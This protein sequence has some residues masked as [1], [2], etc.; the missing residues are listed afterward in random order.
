M[1]G[2]ANGVTMQVSGVD[3]SQQTAFGA[4]LLGLSATPQL[5][6]GYST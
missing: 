2:Q 5:E 3:A 4:G 6:S 1:A